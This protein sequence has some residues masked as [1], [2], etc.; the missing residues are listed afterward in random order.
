MKPNLC[1][2]SLSACVWFHFAWFASEFAGSVNGFEF[3]MTGVVVWLV[4]CW[5]NI[6]KFVDLKQVILTESW[7][8]T[9]VTQFYV[10]RAFQLLRSR[11]VSVCCVFNRNQSLGTLDHLKIGLTRGISIEFSERMW[12]WLWL[13]NFSKDE[14]E[15]NHKNLFVGRTHQSSHKMNA[16]SANGTSLCHFLR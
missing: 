10:W 1:H 7:A 12:I 2:F 8:A 5:H 15:K 14:H 16:C 6:R 13:F 4:G 3:I 9:W 11:F